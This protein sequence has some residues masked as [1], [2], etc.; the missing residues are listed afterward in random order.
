MVGEYMRISWI[1]AKNDEKSFRF[2]QN[3]GWNVFEIDD[4]EDTDK[5]I[6]KLIKGNCNTIILSNEVAGFSEDIIK[7][8]NKT[9][10]VNIII[11][12]HKREY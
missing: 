4:L 2:Q 7:R 8:Y 6:A 1:K 11:A 5:T 10:E 12:P 9:D 3:M